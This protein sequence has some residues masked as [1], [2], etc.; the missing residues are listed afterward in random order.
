MFAIPGIVA[1]LTFIY[2][3]PHEL[4][5]A[6]RTLPLLYV[7]CALA[8]FGLTLD[9]RLGNLRA[10]A[11]PQLPWTLLFA[12]WGLFTAVL[13]APWTVPRAILTVGIPLLL[14][15]VV[16]HGVQSFRALAALSTVV[17]ACVLWI[18]SVGVNQGT[19]G[20]GCIEVDQRQM[21]ELVG[22]KPDGRPCET[23]EQC[24]VDG[25]EP[26]KDFVCEKVS[27]LDTASV[28]GGRVRYLGVL[29]DP[30]EMALA[31]CVGL[32]FAIAFFEQKKSRT[33]TVLLIATFALVAVCTVFTQSR[34]GQMVFLAVLGAYF[35]KR[36]GWKGA[37]AGILLAAPILLLGGRGGDEADA[38]SKERLECWYAGMS[39]F[40]THPF[41]GVGLKQFTE[42][43]VLTAHNSYVLAAAELGLP[44]FF[45][46]SVVLYLSAKIPLTAL[47]KYEAVPE[48]R[49]AR[50]WSM[51]LVAAFAGLILGIF[52]LSFCYH[53]VL[54]IYIGLSGAL[55]SAIR[56]HDRSYQVRVGFRELAGILAADVAIVLVMFVYTRAKVA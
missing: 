53:Y 1:L 4:V 37:F 38:S 33:R 7:F 28:G 19:S 3:R 12:A 15:L 6:F 35:L 29:Q 27:F 42:H 41:A 54:W 23:R 24:L 11:T 22:G 52:F 47:F 20:Y 48:A 10:E 39:M 46:F 21:R 50:S 56:T 25:R 36:F 18:A 2:A 49:I 34:G 5:E 8:A 26:G 14:Y 31:I 30:N 13:Q 17:L 43:H 32:P 45:F 51:A 55:Y 9:L 44:G 16:A 40:K